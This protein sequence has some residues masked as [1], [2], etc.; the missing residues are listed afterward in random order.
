L[1][2]GEFSDQHLNARYLAEQGAALTLRPR[3]LDDLADTALRL[4]A[5]GPRR[6]TM[7]EAMRA[8]ARPH[9]A[10]RLATM[11]REMARERPA[12]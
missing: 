12:A 5:D 11:L 10:E 3:E 2:P 9:A 7:A 1:I 8:L 4:L 6:A